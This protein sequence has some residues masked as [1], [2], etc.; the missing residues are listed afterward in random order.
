MAEFD[1]VERRKEVV[2]QLNQLNIFDVT[3]LNLLELE[4]LLDDNKEIGNFRK[5]D[6]V[7]LETNGMGDF[8]VEDTKGF[9]YTYVLGTIIVLDGDRMKFLVE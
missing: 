4:E 5:S 1:C 8:I 6:I 7:K 9:I 3:R 2:K